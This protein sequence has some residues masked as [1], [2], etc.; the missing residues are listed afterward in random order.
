V[1]QL[2][3]LYNY[4]S[5]NVNITALMEAIKRM[6]S[7]HATNVAWLN[8]SIDILWFFINRCPSIKYNIQ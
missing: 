8:A 6:N 3:E 4:I 1:P 7:F 2:P 5:T